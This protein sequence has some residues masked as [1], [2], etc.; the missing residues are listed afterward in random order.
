MANLLKFYRGAANMVAQAPVG[1][2]WFDTENDVI[3]VRIATGTETDYP[4]W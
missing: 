3:K 1:A 4:P 2:I